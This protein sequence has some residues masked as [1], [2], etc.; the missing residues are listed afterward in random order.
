MENVTIGLAF[1]A[2][3]LS[4]VSPCVL[5]LVPAYIG[6]MGGRMTRNVA[7]QTAGGEKTKKNPSRSLSA[8]LSLLIHGLAFVSGFTLV[9]IAIGLM[10]T[11]FVSVLGSSV[12]ILTD[13]IG[14]VGG[15]VII[16]F[17][18]HFM[19]ALRWFFM[20]L[21]KRPALLDNPMTTLGVGL[22]TTLITAWAFVSLT[23]ALPFIAGLWL[24]LF[25]GG[26]FTKSGE[27]WMNILNRIEIALYSDTRRDMEMNGTEGLSGSF[28]MGVVFSAGWTPCIGPLLGTILTVAA[29]TGDAGQAVP[30]LT[31]YS[32][33][34][35]IPFLLTAGLINSA[36]GVLRRLQ[37]HMH[38]IELASGALLIV[39]GIAVASGQLQSLSTTLS[40]EQADVS[41][42][43]EECGLGFFGGHLNLNQVGSCMGGTLFP[44]ALGQSHAV[45]VNSDTDMLEFVVLLD[46]PEAIDIEISRLGNFLESIL[47]EEQLAALGI[48]RINDALNV[49]I[50]IVNNAGETIATSDTLRQIAGED[51]KFIVFQN[52]ELPTAGQYTAIVTAD[53][54]DEINFRMRIREAEA[55][56]LEEEATTDMDSAD[57]STPHSNATD[58]EV[59]DLAE[60]GTD[61]EDG[62]AVDELALEALSTIE[63]VAETTG[64][65]VGLDVGNLAPDFTITTIDGD[66][67]TLSELRGQI[68]LVN[69]WGTWC[70]PCRREMPEFQNVYEEYGEEGFTI[71]ALAKLQNDTFEDVVDF[72][73][74]FSLTFPIAVDE[75]DV[76]TDQYNIISQPSTLILDEDGVIAFRSF[77]IV[78]ESQV[79]EVI[80][81]IKA[82]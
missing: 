82:Q 56:E 42:R 30:M 33:G 41:F 53:I 47:E 72:R 62:E 67:V 44:V 55:V 59:V 18:L 1:I 61:A 39:I 7:V 46:E 13:I 40:T 66:T 38:K 81:E 27:F 32:L 75:D 5:P 60:E 21:K 80:N 51:D 3:F 8:R 74:E 48:D 49:T 22:I 10:T 79:T 50:T 25:L 35:G 63:E 52:L 16:I 73:D 17:G 71:L 45:E 43:I 14:R 20:W 24:A 76:V 12:T 70:G 28:F 64:P 2:G 15:V 6:Y 77:G 37:K 4:F 36:Q 78:L 23:V 19:G 9:F 29:Q 34:L 58:A 68:V 69:F 57:M 65:A 54:E 31:A 11:V 26:A